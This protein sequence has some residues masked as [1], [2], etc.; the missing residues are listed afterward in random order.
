MGWVAGLGGD[1]GINNVIFYAFLKMMTAAKI[2]CGGS[3]ERKQKKDKNSCILSLVV[4]MAFSQR[5]LHGDFI[6]GSTLKKQ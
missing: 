3:K 4:E 5:S 1:V 6:W 2:S